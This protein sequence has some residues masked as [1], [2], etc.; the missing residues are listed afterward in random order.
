MLFHMM[1]PLLLI[2]FIYFFSAIFY[3]SNGTPGNI[4]IEHLISDSRRMQLTVIAFCEAFSCSFPFYFKLHIFS[5][6]VEASLTEVTDKADFALKLPSETSVV[7][8]SGDVH[9]SQVVLQPKT[10]M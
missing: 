7:L 5:S 6:L 2:A 4:S 3:T 8:V 10:V 1:N 9:F